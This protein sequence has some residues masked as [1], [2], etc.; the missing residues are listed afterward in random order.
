MSLLL[1]ER[2]WV[3]PR[4]FW[5]F[6]AQGLFLTV[7]IAGVPAGSQQKNARDTLAG[8]SLPGSP[9]ECYLLSET[10]G[11]VIKDSCGHGDG[12]VSGD[13]YSLSPQGVTWEAGGS[14]I[15][16]S[17][18][19]MPRSVLACFTHEFGG[20]RYPGDV[21]KLFEKFPSL[22]TTDGTDGNAIF[23]EAQDGHKQHRNVANLGYLY[24][25]EGRSSNEYIAATSDGT[26]GGP[27]CLVLNRVATGGDQF[28]LDNRRMVTAYDASTGGETLGGGHLVIGGRLADPDYW[29]HGT[30]HL[31]V[32]WDTETLTTQ[33]DVN[34]AMSWANDELRKKGLPAAGVVPPPASDLQS[35]F[36]IVGD[37]IT[38]CQ[39]P[40]IV[41]REQC[42]ALNIHLQN[43]AVVTIPV[44]IGGLSGQFDA[45]TSPWRE[46]TLFDP[47]AAFNIAE[48]YFGPNDGCR[49]QFTEGQLWQ[50]A[51][52]WSRAMHRLGVRTL[53]TTMIDLVNPAGCAQTNESGTAFKNNYN[54]I[55]RNNYRGV[56]DGIV[57]LASYPGLGADGANQGRCFGPDHTHPN[58]TCQG[59]IIQMVEDSANYLLNSG[60]TILSA[61]DYSMK[62]SD[63]ELIV[64]FAPSRGSKVT[65]PSCLGKT[66]MRYTISNSSS[67]SS[68][69]SLTIQPIAGESIFGVIDQPLSVSRGTAVTL[70]PIVAD[71]AAAGC[72]W[73]TA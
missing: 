55:A 14:Q 11:S 20:T 57:D 18:T 3:V 72:T 28:Y 27:H 68:A 23:L 51:V 13:H 29:F 25:T 64:L 48:F 47:N 26:N 61:S 46:E 24:F 39:G 1:L 15:K 65:L 67:P 6:A 71:P 32:L 22:L 35:R 56:F 16:T 9:S 19:I 42:W 38:A 58:P 2:G 31:M 41:T 33:A 59:K 52:Q 60:P 53:F 37:S 17:A 66:G 10:S 63:K 73:T 45:I 4:E 54:A 12:V 70:M 62:A 7:V 40:A 8:Y 43:P 30:L 36:V 44:A 21:T 49:N 5:K 50:R 69:H 34:Q